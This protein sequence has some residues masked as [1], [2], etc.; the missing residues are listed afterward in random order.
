[1][2]L[3]WLKKWLVE[4]WMNWKKSILKWR[5][6]LGYEFPAACVVFFRTEPKDLNEI[7]RL[8]LRSPVVV[9]QS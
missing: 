1:M 3:R 2:R 6:S 7:V 5:S 8:P 4:S 9:F